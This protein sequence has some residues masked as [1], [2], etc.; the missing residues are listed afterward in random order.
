[1]LI[2]STMVHLNTYKKDKQHHTAYKMN[3]NTNN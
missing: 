1:M 3:Q 2:Y